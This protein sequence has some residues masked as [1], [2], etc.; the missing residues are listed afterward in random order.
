MNLG[1]EQGVRPGKSLRN[2]VLFQSR[3]KRENP[4]FSKTNA[5]PDSRF[6]GSGYSGRHG[7]DYIHGEPPAALI[8]FERRIGDIAGS[9]KDVKGSFLYQLFHWKYPLLTLLIYSAYRICEVSRMP[10]FNDSKDHRAGPHGE[11]VSG[12]GLATTTISGGL[13][14]GNRLINTGR[15]IWATQW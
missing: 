5:G 13:P 15:E 14:D 3:A 1:C 2:T 12:T 8:H 6:E 7:D 9:K 10:R 4:T 11:I